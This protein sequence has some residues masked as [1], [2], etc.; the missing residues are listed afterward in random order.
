MFLP[1]PLVVTV[2]E[3]PAIRRVGCDGPLL[4]R[5]V[6]TIKIPTICRVRG[7]MNLLVDVATT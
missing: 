6:T 3:I 2:V 4:C 5:V 1:L 7:D